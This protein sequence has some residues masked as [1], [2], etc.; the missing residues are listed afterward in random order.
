MHHPVGA[1][2]LGFGGCHPDARRRYHTG[3]PA[4]PPRG[5]RTGDLCQRRHSSAKTCPTLQDRLAAPDLRQVGPR[6]SAA[7][8]ALTFSPTAVASD[9]QQPPGYRR[10]IPHRPFLPVAVPHGPLASPRV[11]HPTGAAAFLGWIWIYPATERRQ[12]GTRPD[13]R[14]G[15]AARWGASF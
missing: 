4:R 7:I 2:P 12:G 11:L 15:H 13:L 1:A 8:L 6:A 10:C 3:T 14:R 5:G 9:G